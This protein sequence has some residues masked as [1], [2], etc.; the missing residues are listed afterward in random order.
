MRLILDTHAFL[1][2]VG[3]DACLSD[4]ARALILDPTNRRLLSAASL[5]EMAIKSSLGRLKLAFPFPEL[6]ERQVHGNAMEML[7]A[8]PAH[9]DELVRL[10]F[11]HKDP[12]GRL[13]IAQA[14]AEEVPVITHDAAFAHYDVE[15]LWSEPPR[16]PAV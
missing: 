3:G 8:L 2:F 14:I 9:L 6:V 7:P 11:H 1:W 15:V 5:W 16:Q 4:H 10:P 13:L 12:F